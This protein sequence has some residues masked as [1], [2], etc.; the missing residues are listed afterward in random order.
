MNRFWKFI[1]LCLL[2]FISISLFS[3]KPVLR[4][5]FPLGYHHVIAEEANQYDFDP[6][7]LAALIQVE[8]GFRPRVVSPKGATGLM[9]LMPG[10]AFWVAD[11]LDM[12]ITED[13]LLNPT[14]NIRLGSYYINHLRAKFPTLVAAL[15]AYNGGQGNVAQWL[16]TN[17]WDGRLE[18]IEDIPFYETRN[19]IRRVLSTWEFLQSIYDNRFEP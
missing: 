12:E 5:F 14:V 18:T 11:Q 15:A 3:V 8:S 16:A 9:Q 6:F 10:T 19:Y 7:F 13:D 1:T 17:R 2:L 4:R